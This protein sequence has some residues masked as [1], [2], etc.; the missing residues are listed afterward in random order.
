M[1]NS[2]LSVDELMSRGLGKRWK[3]VSCCVWWVCGDLLSD[4]EHLM[5]RKAGKYLF[6]SCPLRVGAQL[7]IH[8]KRWGGFSQEGF[9]ELRTTLLINI[10]MSYFLA[11]WPMCLIELICSWESSLIVRQ[12]K[13]NWNAKKQAREEEINNLSWPSSKGQR[14]PNKAWSSLKV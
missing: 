9:D 12:E 3:D 6:M 10:L 2:S 8:V 14:C 5:H 1:S 7:H 11:A 13:H 4:L